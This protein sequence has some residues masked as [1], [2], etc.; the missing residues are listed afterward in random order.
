[1]N[2]TVRPAVDRETDAQ[3][4]GHLNRVD[5]HVR[6]EAERVQQPERAADRHHGDDHRYGGGKQ[7]TEDED[8][9]EQHDRQGQRL[10]SL[11]VGLGLGA[12]LVAGQ[13]AAGDDHLSPV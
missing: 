12:E 9:Q 3:H 7:S 1:V 5:R 10:G 11:H 4:G 8:E 2:S 13:R 6:D